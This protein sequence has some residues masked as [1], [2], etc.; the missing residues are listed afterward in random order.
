[1]SIKKDFEK[2]L[3]SAIKDNDITKKNVLRMALSSIKL[4]EVELGKELTD[5]E[6][7]A[8]LQK[9]IKTREETISEAEKANRIEMIKPNLDEIAIIKEYLPKEL[10]EEELISLIK[11]I[12]HKLGATTIKETGLVM[13]TAIQEVQGKASNDRISKIVREI[14][15]NNP[16]AQ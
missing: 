3:L 6:I 2:Q 12:V 10:S 5:P 13:K 7:Y 15:S 1:M 9:E 11:S 4:S 8:I 16:S 14:L